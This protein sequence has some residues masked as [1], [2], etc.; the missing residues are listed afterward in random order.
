MIALH[1]DRV[2]RHH[3]EWHVSPLDDPESILLARTE[4]CSGADDGLR[5]ANTWLQDVSGH[6]VSRRLALCGTQKKEFSL[7]Q[8]LTRCGWLR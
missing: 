3:G 5:L 6:G 1:P 8:Y 2:Q 4:N 7:R